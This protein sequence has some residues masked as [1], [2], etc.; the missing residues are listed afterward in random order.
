MLSVVPLFMGLPEGTAF[1]VS[2]VVQFVG[3][4]RGNGLV[5]PFIAVVASLLHLDL[6]IRR[7]AYDVDLITRSGATAP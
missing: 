1:V 7:E 3:R 6:R 2:M 4:R 5:L